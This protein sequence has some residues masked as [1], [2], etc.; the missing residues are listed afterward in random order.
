M[1]KTRVFAVDPN[2][3]DP[4]VMAEAARV[5]ISGGL[6]AFPTETVYGLGASALDAVAVGR[7][8]AAKERPATDPVIV[9]LNGPDELG[10]VCP[11]T[12]DSLAAL[13]KAFWPGP[14]T[15]IVP[16][17]PAVPDAVSAGGDTVGVRVP[18]HPVA[19]ALL[20]AASVPVA[21]PSA[22]RFSRPSP[23]RA[24]HVLADLD[25]RIDLILDGGPTSVGVESS[26]VDLTRRPPRLLRPGGI[27]L[28]AL[29]ALL[30][31]LVVV[32][33]F[34]AEAEAAESPGQFL[35]H[36][37]PRTPLLAVDGPAEAAVL[38]LMQ[39]ARRAAAEGRRVGVLVFD[40]DAAVLSNAPVVL[41]LSLGPETD[42]RVAAARLYEA[43]RDLDAARVDQLLVR[44][45]GPDGLGLALRDRLT[46]AAEGRVV[47]PGSTAVL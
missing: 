17:G 14:L 24:E 1:P 5:L 44:L 9:H 13:A 29:R 45:P 42:L 37:A 3:P 31:D 30:P 47:R 16:R 43:L 41:C 35:K 40:E 33:R 11:A 39:I 22:N 6:V 38:A 10:Q 26:I 20:H 28:E 12:P 19:R 27:S 25:G 18:A 8:F 34:T 46:R 21:A 4:A 2:Q 7:I 23:T 15:L 36:Y 32:E